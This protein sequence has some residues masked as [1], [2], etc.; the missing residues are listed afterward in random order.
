MSLDAQFVSKLLSGIKEAGLGKEIDEKNAADREEIANTKDDVILG[1][2]R[3]LLRSPRAQERAKREE[4]EAAEVKVKAKA[5]E[6]ETEAEEPPSEDMVARWAATFEELDEDKLALVAE[7]VQRVQA[8][9]AIA[10]YD[11]ESEEA[12]DEEWDNYIETIDGEDD[13]ETEEEA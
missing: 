3:T 12:T 10:N 2:A 6:P 11:I 5:A 4:R 1:R 7:G 8:E 13:E 9:Q